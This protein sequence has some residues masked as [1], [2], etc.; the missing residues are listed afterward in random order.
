M[1]LFARS[2]VDKAVQEVVERVIESISGKYIRTVDEIKS[3]LDLSDQVARLKIEKSQIEESHQRR[4]REIEH[5]LGL[6]KKRQETE[7][8]L[9][10]REATIK[11]EEKFLEQKKELFTTEMTFT[12]KRMEEEVGYLKDMVG[13]VLERLPSA[14]IIATINSGNKKET[15]HRDVSR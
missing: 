5:K 9:A 2:P 7:L 6:E 14:E 10:K 8:E 3:A 12:R 11:A 13:Q 15:R 4:E 1:W